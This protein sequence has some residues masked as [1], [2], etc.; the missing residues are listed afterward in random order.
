VSFRKGRHSGCE[1]RGPKA[2]KEGLL[3]P[4]VASTGDWLGH[5]RRKEQMEFCKIYFQAVMEGT[6]G[7]CFQIFSHPTFMTH[8]TRFEKRRLCAK[9][10]LAVH[11]LGLPR[12]SKSRGR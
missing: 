2:H 4:V 8:H 11:V 6:L 7:S 3:L 5:Q 1:G 9:V 12:R 10:L